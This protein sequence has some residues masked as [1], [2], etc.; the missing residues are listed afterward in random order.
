MAWWGVLEPQKKGHKQATHTLCTQRGAWTQVGTPS[1][2]H[3]TPHWIGAWVLNT[4]GE[5]VTLRC[6]PLGQ[7]SC[8]PSNFVSIWY[9]IRAPGIKG[10]SYGR[11]RR[12]SGG[13][14]DNFVDIGSVFVILL[15]LYPFQ[16]L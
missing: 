2:R 8:C 9:S 1:K 15:F 6:S 16:S 10:T 3:M 11:D 14:A 5:L 12:K 13:G 4:D 7:W